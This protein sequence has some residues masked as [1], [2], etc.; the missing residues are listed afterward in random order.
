MNKSNATVT[1]SDENISPD[2]PNAPIGS[3]KPKG[4]QEA[5][6]PY[7]SLNDEEIDSHSK[8][9]TAPS[10]RPGPHT[11]TGNNPNGDPPDH[12]VPPELLPSLN[13][14]IIITNDHPFYQDGQQPNI[15]EIVHDLGFPEGHAFP[16]YNSNPGGKSYYV[17]TLTTLNRYGP[18]WEEDSSTDSRSPTSDVNTQGL[19]EPEL[20]MLSTE[21]EICRQKCG[22]QTLDASNPF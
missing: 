13:G 2:D 21:L 22:P 3:S 10:A 17:S 8:T 16:S 11:T 12:G 1:A 7:P 19:L 14:N 15:N 5:T 20:T 6:R 9:S 18:Q 4:R